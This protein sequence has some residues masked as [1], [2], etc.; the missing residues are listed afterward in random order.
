[1]LR[2]S[3][4]HYQL[5]QSVKNGLD[6]CLLCFSKVVTHQNVIQTTCQVMYDCKLVMMMMMSGPVHT[7][8]EKFENASSFFIRLVLPFTLVRHE[9]RASRKRSSNRRNL[10]T[11]AFGFRADGKGF[12]NGEE[13]KVGELLPEYFCLY[14]PTG[15]LY[16]S[17][18]DPQLQND[19]QI[20][21]SRYLFRCYCFMNSKGSLKCT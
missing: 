1:M 14:P 3:S 11:P 5:Q 12:E 10:K 9:N 19:P 13:I 21:S 8:P 15:C 4:H 20:E 6:L 2:S 17:Q 7:T 18:E 16:S